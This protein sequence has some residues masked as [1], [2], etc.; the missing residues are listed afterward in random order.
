MSTTIKKLVDRGVLLFCSQRLSAVCLLGERQL[1]WHSAAASY[2]SY[3]ERHVA[4]RLDTCFFSLSLRAQSGSYV[5]S[6]Y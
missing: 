2:T 4:S 1:L 6:H 5:T 3:Q